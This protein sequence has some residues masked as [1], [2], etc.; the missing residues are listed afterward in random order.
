MTASIPGVQPPE[1]QRR[2][3]V[4]AY[5]RIG[6]HGDVGEALKLTLIW[7]RSCTSVVAWPFFSAEGVTSG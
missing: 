6:E 5:R 4:S 1:H 7:T 2:V 3:G